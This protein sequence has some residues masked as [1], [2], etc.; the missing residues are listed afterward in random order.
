MESEVLAYLSHILRQNLLQQ[1]VLVSILVRKHNKFYQF[2]L[3]CAK[4]LYLL[5]GWAP[6]REEKRNNQI[7]IISSFMNYCNYSNILEDAQYLWERKFQQK[8]IKKE[9]PGQIWIFL[10]FLY[11]LPHFLENQVL[12]YFQNQSLVIMSKIKFKKIVFK[13]LL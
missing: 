11:P 2:P 3:L 12:N 13:M 6:C 1:F 10:R 7:F 8:V 9:R 4:V 5:H